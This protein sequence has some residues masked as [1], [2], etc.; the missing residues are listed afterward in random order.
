MLYAI[1]GTD[2]PEIELALGAKPSDIS[3]QK[4][5]FPYKKIDSRLITS[6]LDVRIS[7]S[8]DADLVDIDLHVDEPTGETVN[9]SHRDS[10]IGGH[11]SRDFQDGYDLKSTFVAG[12]KG[13]IRFVRIIM[14][15]TSKAL[16]VHVL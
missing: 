1:H 5:K 11:V 12:I 8:W 14:V 13:R 15:R 7:M 3:G 10:A 2:S 16:R 4:E 6:D 9:Y